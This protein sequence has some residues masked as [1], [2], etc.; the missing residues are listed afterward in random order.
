M[1]KVGGARA[2]AGRKP[3]TLNKKS[4]ELLHGVISEG[5]TPVEYMLKIMRDEK[6][7]GKSRAWAAERAA[8]FI[9]PRPAPIQRT[10][11]I[12]LPAINDAKD[13]PTAVA[14]ILKA[15]ANGEIS[16]SEAQSFVSIIEVHRK[17]IETGE[18]LERLEA[19]ETKAA[20][21]KS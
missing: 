6:A 16:P 11:K 9:H 3:G 21:K 5:V 1:A 13:I 14:D 2:G 17:A 20:E 12:E 19:L 15:A 10:V 4:V 18:I 7:D 8:P